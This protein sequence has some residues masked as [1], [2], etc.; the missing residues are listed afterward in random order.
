MTYGIS[1][2]IAVIKTLVMRRMIED[3]IRAWLMRIELN[4]EK[5]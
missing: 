4:L 5:T 2:L 3:S 1:P